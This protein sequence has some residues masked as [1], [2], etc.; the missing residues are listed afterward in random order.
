MQ[1]QSK[2]RQN[3]IIPPLQDTENTEDLPNLDPEIIPFEDPYES[4]PNEEPIPGEGP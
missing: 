3:G 1:N 2:K 4:P